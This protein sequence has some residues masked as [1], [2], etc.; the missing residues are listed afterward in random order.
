M[1]MQDLPIG[2][3]EDPGTARPAAATRGDYAG[4]AAT[5]AVVLCPP[6]S[7]GRVCGKSFT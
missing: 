4:I 6:S 5:T 2:E 1:R 7:S 3:E